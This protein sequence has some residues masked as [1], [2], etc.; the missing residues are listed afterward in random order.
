VGRLLREVGDKVHEKVNAPVPEKG[1][2]G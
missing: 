2:R 1:D